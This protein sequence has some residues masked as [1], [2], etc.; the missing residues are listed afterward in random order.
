[1]IQ[2][3]WS[4]GEGRIAPKKMYSATEKGRQEIRHR[5]EIW[6]NFTAV[7]DGFYREGEDAQ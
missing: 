6:M 3:S 2:S 7:V 1:M 4:Q 5:W